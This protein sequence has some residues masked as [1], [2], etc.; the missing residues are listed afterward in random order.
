M[1]CFCRKDRKFNIFTLIP[2]TKED[3]D[4]FWVFRRDDVIFMF[5]LGFIFI[6][7]AWLNALLVYVGAPDEKSTNKFQ[8]GTFILALNVIIFIIGR[9]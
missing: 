1:K 9:F 4:L 7:S 2:N 8:F 5:T 6:I 3:R